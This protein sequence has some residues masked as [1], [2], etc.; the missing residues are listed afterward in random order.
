MTRDEFMDVV[1]G[2]WNTWEDDALILDKEG[3]RFADAS[4]VHRLDHHG[5]WFQLARTV[6]RARSPQGHPVLIQAGQS[7][8]RSGVRGAVGGTGVRDPSQPGSRQEAVCRV[9]G[10]RCRR[11]RDPASVHVAPACYVCVAESEAAAQEKQAI[12]ERPLGQSTRWC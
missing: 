1:M 12:I 10:R 9:Q 2:H 7:G 11:S 6:Q 8:S 4:K 3:N 5:E